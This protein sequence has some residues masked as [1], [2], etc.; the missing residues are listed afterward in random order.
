MLTK[1][2]KNSHTNNKLDQWIIIIVDNLLKYVLTDIYATESIAYQI[3]YLLKLLIE[4]TY[5]NWLLKYQKG[6]PNLTILAFSK[7][8][9]API[10]TFDT[11][12][13]SSS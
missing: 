9:L 5:Q 12:L 10:E 8:Q 2:S 11:T 13:E 7:V 3:Y 1:N 6:L 4:E